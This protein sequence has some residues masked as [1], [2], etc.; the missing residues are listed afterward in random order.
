MTQP[1]KPLVPRLGGN[2]PLLIFE[3][4]WGNVDDDDDDNDDDDNDHDNNDDMDD[5]GGVTTTMTMTKRR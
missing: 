3:V 5:S 4:D 2:R 1:K